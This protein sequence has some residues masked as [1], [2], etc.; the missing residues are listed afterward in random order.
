VTYTPNPPPE[1]DP[2]ID[3][4][5]PIREPEPDDP[6]ENPPKQGVAKQGQSKSDITDALGTPDA[7]ELSGGRECWSY[8]TSNGKALSRVRVCFV[9]G[10]VADVRQ[11]F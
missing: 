10:Q 3:P 1:N 5:P 7:T 11:G 8:Y 9:E 4:Q 6:D 2:P